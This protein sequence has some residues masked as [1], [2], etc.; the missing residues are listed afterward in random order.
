[1]ERSPGDVGSKLMGTIVHSYTSVE[2]GQARIGSGT[3]EMSIESVRLTGTYLALDNKRAMRIEWS[4][5][6]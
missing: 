6:F 2:R 1:M 5:P 4:I 3:L